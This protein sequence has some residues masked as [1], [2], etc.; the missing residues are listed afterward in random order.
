MNNVLLND[1]NAEDTV[2]ENVNEYVAS[3]RLRVLCA[4]VDTL[5][6]K[7]DE[8]SVRVFSENP[9]V[10]CLQEVLPKNTYG[11]IEVEIDLKIN[12]YDMFKP[13]EMKRGVITLIKKGIHTIQ[14]EP[15]E[16]F[17]ESVWCMILNKDSER[18]LVG[19]IY[20]SPSSDTQN[21]QRMCSAINEMCG[22][23]CSQVII[24]GDFN[25]K[26]IDWERHQVHVTEDHPA[27]LLLECVDDNFL[28]QHVT[29]NTRF[30]EGQASNLLD[31]VFT[32][33][34]DNVTRLDYEMPFGRSDHVC[35]MFEV[36]CHRHSE[37]EGFKRK[38]FKGNYPEIRN[39]I[40]MIDW[41]NELRDKDTEESWGILESVIK[42][43]VERNVPMQ[44]VF[45]TFKKKW[46]TQEVL[47]VVKEKHKAYKKYRR[48]RTNESKDDYNRAKQMAIYVTKKARTEFET[49]IANNIKENP[50]EFYSYVN[51][52][53]TVRSEIAVLKNRDGELAI[54]PHE[55]AEM[56]NT[57]FASV[58]TKEDTANIPEP[59]SKVLQSMLSTI[60]VTE[61]MVRDRLKE[62][63]PGK[64]AG[65][66]GIH[67]RVVV[68][69]QE[70]LVGPF[71]IIFNKSLSEGVVPDSWKEAEVVPIFKK[72]KRDDPG[73]YRPVS[74]TSV[75]GKI[76]EKIVRKEIVD[77]LERNEVI[78]D[79][80]HGFVQ[81]KSCQ[82]QLLTV[83][84]EWTKWMEE[85][86]PFDC[87]YFDYRKAFDSVPHMRLMR[88]IES[89][90]ITGQVQRWIKSFLQGRRQ[91]VRVG[92]AVSG[93]KK[94]TSGIPQGSVLGPTLFVLF[95]NDLPQVVESRVALFADDTKVFREIQS[96]EDREK[97]QQDIDELLIWSKKWQLPFNESKCKVMHYGKTNR[98]AD[99]NLGGVQI[100][101]V[102]EEKDLGVTFDQQLSFGTNA[103]KVVA[104][105]N[106]TLGLINRH[107]R[108]I[109]T[110][111]FMNLYKTLVR[112]KVEYCMTV[113]QPVYKKDKEKIERVQHRATKLVLGME[114][115]EYSERL[116]ELKLP[117][118]EYRRKRAD[119]MQTYKIMNNIDK[120]DEKKFFKPC[121]EVRTRG[122]T[123]RVQKTQCKSLVRRNTFSQ[124][125]V[126]DWNALPDAVVT[127]GSINQFKGRLGRWWKNDPIMYQNIR[128]PQA[129]KHSAIALYNAREGHQP[130]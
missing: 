100:V 69:T 23:D 26:E 54:L 70:Q 61:Q 108:H 8:L 42:E 7:M 101:E 86:K 63:K 46:M 1:D 81:G 64:S 129:I 37:K 92:E 109:E 72:G 122:H 55:K 32:D 6:N 24:C 120:I 114:N 59:E 58:F 34:D 31:L 40:N 85:R 105:A 27:S 14:I 118:L 3:D 95:I 48:L 20:R 41:E 38:Y 11:E 93:W 15:T 5:T 13:N 121:K 17:D 33:R 10:I 60:I 83:I 125:V 127:S 62:Q 124:R 78:S 88:K 19:N 110:K 97:L 113:A 68:E 75:C 71:T 76:M 79:V 130:C 82:T 116:A 89:C 57:F 22:K 107:F 87:L 117:S 21:A 51:N 28:I 74:L 29:E 65:P 123:M 18:I 52:K 30:R 96:D 2:L 80:Q 99:Y 91:R 111:P 49:R 44:K 126:N 16:H 25:L 47:N 128:S 66:D 102:S 9:D 35:L 36:L 73:N 103:S 77:H 12:G 119:V 94:V 84:E 53:T 67:S 56:L 50:K 115:K 106:S 39:D 45:K 90:G 98:K 4:N 43:S 112:P 104:A